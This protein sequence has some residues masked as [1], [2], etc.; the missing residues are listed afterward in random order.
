MYCKSYWILCLVQ[1]TCLLGIMAA[2]T[3]IQAMCD[4]DRMQHTLPIKQLQH[5]VC[6][7]AGGGD[8]SLLSPTTMMLSIALVM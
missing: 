8:N 5:E 7:R 4:G 2:L 3:A 1:V 6:K